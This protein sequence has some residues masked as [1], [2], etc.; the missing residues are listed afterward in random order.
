MITKVEACRLAISFTN[1]SNMIG[2]HRLFNLSESYVVALQNKSK[3]LTMMP[4]SV[5]KHT[6][7]CSTYYL[8]GRHLEMLEK[9]RMIEVPEDYKI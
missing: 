6:G 4:V 9:S 7:E 8:D 5:N 3:N 1:A 2:V